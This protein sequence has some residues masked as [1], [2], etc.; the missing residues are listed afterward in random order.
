MSMN[1]PREE[2]TIWGAGVHSNYCALPIKTVAEAEPVA[3]A[4]VV[5]GA[6]ADFLRLVAL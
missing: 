5:R 4:A 2:S 3:L 6:P 1:R